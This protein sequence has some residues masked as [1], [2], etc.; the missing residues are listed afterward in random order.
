MISILDINKR[1]VETKSCR[2]C[3]IGWAIYNNHCYFINNNKLN[4][5][6]ANSFCNAYGGFLIKINDQNEYNTLHSFS[7]KYSLNTF[8]VLNDFKL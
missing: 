7:Q 4:W 1:S 6:S 3:P 8:W 2:Y 5:K